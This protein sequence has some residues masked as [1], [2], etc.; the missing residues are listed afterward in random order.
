MVNLTKKQK[1]KA[2]IAALKNRIVENKALQAS[3]Y[4]FASQGVTKASNEKLM[5]SAVIVEMRYLGGKEVCEPFA[6][7]DGLSDSTIE[8]IK[9]DLKRSFDQATM[10]KL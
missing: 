4:H 9:A 5:G 6:I 3:N 10:F 7:L 8:A 2:E 1:R